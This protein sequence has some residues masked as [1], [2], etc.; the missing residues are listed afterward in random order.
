MEYY[1]KRKAVHAY[2][3]KLVKPVYT[4]SGLTDMEFSILM[5]LHYY[6]ETNTSFVKK[7]TEGISKK[8]VE[9]F[10]SLIDRMYANIKE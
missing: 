4:K 1:Q 9:L 5:F 10:D 3:Q 6:P 2:Y 7:V 8:E